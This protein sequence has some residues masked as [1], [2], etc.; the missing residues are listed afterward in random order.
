MQPE[1]IDD[2]EIMNKMDVMLTSLYENSDP[3]LSA[4][5]PFEGENPAYFTIFSLGRLAAYY[6]RSREEGNEPKHSILFA[7]ATLVNNPSTQVM[8]SNALGQA[9]HKGVGGNDV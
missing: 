5:Y 4:I 3:F 9:I 2:D 6:V 7:L 8:V 1:W